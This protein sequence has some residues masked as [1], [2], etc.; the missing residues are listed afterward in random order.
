[1]VKW[2]ASPIFR[3]SKVLPH[4]TRL[5]LH[6][7]VRL[8]IL[9]KRNESFG[10]LEP[11]LVFV[12]AKDTFVVILILLLLLECARLDG[13]FILLRLHNLIGLLAGHD[14]LNLAAY[15]LPVAVIAPREPA[16]GIVKV[17]HCCELGLAALAYK[18]ACCHSVLQRRRLRLEGRAWLLKLILGLSH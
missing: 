3:V 8:I 11:F 2:P 14:S 18:F 17:Y 7:I 6:F 16:V 13:S 15:L 12:P 9:V 4:L 5:K 10:A 1:M